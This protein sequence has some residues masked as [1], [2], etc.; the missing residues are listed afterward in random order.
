MIT[1]TNGY[2]PTHLT[3]RSQPQGGDPEWNNTWSRNR[4]ILID[5][6]TKRAIASTSAYM[7]NCYRMTLGQ[8]EFLPLKSVFVPLH[9]N[10]R[11]W[12]NYK[13]AYVDEY[14]AAAESISPAALEAS[15]VKLDR[16]VLRHA[17]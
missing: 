8:G 12:G 5:A 6:C 13:F 10:G 3:L 7:L 17:A 1:D 2:L 11:R 15:L 9:F 16:P 14:T 4:R